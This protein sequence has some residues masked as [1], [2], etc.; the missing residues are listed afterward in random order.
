MQIAKQ[1]VVTIDY[2]LTDEQGEVLDT[3][4]GQEPLVYIQ[5]SGSIIPGLETALEGKSAGD[6]LKVTVAPEHGYGP[7]D[8]ELVQAVPRD[9]FPADA[10][11]TEGMRFHAQGAGGSHVVTVLSVDDKQVTVDANH[12]LA[13]VT[14]AFDVKV[15]EVR[16]ATTDELEHGHVHGEDGHHHH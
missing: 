16:D 15:V 4:K 8:E 6:T 1:K 14:L 3:S 12:P 11:I 13:G 2:T 5:G 7:R 10:D 9:R